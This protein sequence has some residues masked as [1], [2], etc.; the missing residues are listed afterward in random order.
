MSK[1]WSYYNNN[2]DKAWFDSS[3]VK[4][5]ECVD[6]ES[7]LKTLRVVFNNGSKYEYK[8]VSVQDYLLFREDA[9]Q[10]KAMN[11]YIKAKKYEYERLEDADMDSINKELEFRRNGGIFV[12]YTDGTLKL[13]NSTDNEIFSKNVDLNDDSFDAV[14]GV[15]CAVGKDINVLS[16][17]DDGQK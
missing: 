13:F 15:L 9:S 8:D 4:Y 3:N 16:G 1:I 7:D 14:C 5:C 2:L 12:D 17:V 10:G 11:K 6:K